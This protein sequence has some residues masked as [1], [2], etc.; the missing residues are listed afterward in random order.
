MEKQKEV[1]ICH[2]EVA[3][4]EWLPHYRVA[5]RAG[6]NNGE[7]NRSAEEAFKPIDKLL[8]ELGSLAVAQSQG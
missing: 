5:Q 7:A 3:R 6:G 8:D 2:L 4:E 1:V